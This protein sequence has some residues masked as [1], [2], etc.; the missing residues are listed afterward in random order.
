[1][2]SQRSH[3]EFTT[4]SQQ[5]HN[6]VTTISQRFHNDFTTISHNE[7]TQRVK[8]DFL[9][10]FGSVNFNPFP[11]NLMTFTFKGALFT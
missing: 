9:C 11:R 5:V 3:N 4:I 2:N 8:N 1:M 7:F 6:E 10:M